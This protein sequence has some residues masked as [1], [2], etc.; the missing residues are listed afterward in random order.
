MLSLAGLCF[1]VCTRLV[2]GHYW[3]IHAAGHK[4]VKFLE[5][6]PYSVGGPPLHDPFRSGD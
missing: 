3:D 4:D 2:L 6:F 5:I 1:A